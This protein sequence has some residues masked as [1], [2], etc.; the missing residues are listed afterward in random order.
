MPNLLLRRNRL[1]RALFTAVLVCSD[2]DILLVMW[3]PRKL[4]LLTRS[5]TDTLD[6][7]RGLFV[8][9]FHVVHNQLLSL[10]QVDGEIVVLAP[11]CQVSELLPIGC[12][13]VVSDQAYHRRVVNNLNDGVGVV[14][15][16]TVVGEEGVQQGAKHTPRRGLQV[17][18]YPHRLGTAHQKVQ[19]TIAEG[20]V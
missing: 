17:G 12:L 20:G 3:T 1:C 13:I 5:T 14:C 8:P 4:K 11:H 15:Y 10:A 16:F 6:V 18:V 19:Y 9:P 2:H 7:N